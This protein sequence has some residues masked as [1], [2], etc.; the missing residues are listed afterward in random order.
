MGAGT[1]TKSG[2]TDIE[3]G[4]YDTVLAGPLRPPLLFASRIEYCR[5]VTGRQKDRLTVSHIHYQ[6]GSSTM[7]LMVNGFD[8][9]S[10]WLTHS[11]G[12]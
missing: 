2:T 8:K 9:S 10:F 12:Y 5:Y 4:H 11:F 7:T 3:E 1:R 6:Q